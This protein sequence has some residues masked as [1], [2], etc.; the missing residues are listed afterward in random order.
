MQRLSNGTLRFF[1]RYGIEVRAVP[2]VAKM[3]PLDSAESP[4]LVPYRSQWDGSRPDYPMIMDTLLQSDGLLV[5][6]AS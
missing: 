3:G 5:P 6:E 4:A 2:K 1:N